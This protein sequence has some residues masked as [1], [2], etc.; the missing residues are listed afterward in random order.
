MLAC[1]FWNHVNN[2]YT[3]ILYTVYIYNHTHPVLDGG[4]KY[5][6]CGV[7]IQSFCFFTEHSDQD[8]S[9]HFSIS[10][11]LGCGL[12]INTPQ[13]LIHNDYSRVHARLCV[14]TCD[15]LIICCLPF[16]F[17]SFPLFTLYQ[18]DSPPSFL[19]PTMRHGFYQGAQ[20]VKRC[21]DVKPHSFNSL[22][23]LYFPA[24][25]RLLW[26]CCTSNN[27]LKFHIVSR[28]LRA[29]AA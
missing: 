21:L 14:C 9:V 4:G 2:F 23:F 15:T 5:F 26:P 20:E 1:V 29:N 28:C 3:N 25:F 17:L 13:Y 12:P 7:Y 19:F 11:S 22:L 27:T 8:C 6:S 10:V 18:R 24:P 16:V